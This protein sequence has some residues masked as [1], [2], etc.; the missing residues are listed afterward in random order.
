MS[1]CFEAKYKA[2]SWFPIAECALPKLQHALPAKQ[3]FKLTEHF[4]FKKLV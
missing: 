3:N 4:Y 2:F 1:R